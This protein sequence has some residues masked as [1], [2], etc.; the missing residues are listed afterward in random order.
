MHGE[1]NTIQVHHT[2]SASPERVFD[3]WLD[4]AKA[5]KFLF[6]TPTG[7]MVKAEI[8]ARV[9]GRFLFVDRRDG[10]DV[11]HT[12][13]YL[14]IERP[15]RLVFSFGVPQFSPEF[16]RVTVEIK[17]QGTG[18]VLILTHEGVLPDYQDRTQA[19]W[20]MILDGLE[21]AVQ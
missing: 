13:E 3:A 21:K 20:R 8:D 1:R 18:C 14:E 4:P 5:A 12:G 17:P 7:Q 16:T 2:F 6:A 10:T 19:G 15:S 9:G 11:E